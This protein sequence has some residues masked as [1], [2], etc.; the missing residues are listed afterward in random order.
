MRLGWM[1]PIAVAR[2][3]LCLAPLLLGQCRPL[4]WL[5]RSRGITPPILA[6][7]SANS[8]AQGEWDIAAPWI[9]VFAQFVRFR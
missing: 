1:N 7:P 9:F 2:S 5:G 4:K 8:V 3:A 6:R